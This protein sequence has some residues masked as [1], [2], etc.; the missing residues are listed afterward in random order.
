MYDTVSERECVGE[1]VSET[2]SEIEGLVV[3]TV[4]EAL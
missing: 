3:D 2:S 1:S 4:N